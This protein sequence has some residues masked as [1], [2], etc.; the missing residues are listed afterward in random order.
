MLSRPI[1]KKVLL[2]D[3]DGVVLHHPNIQYYVSMR[4]SSY[5][6]EKLKPQV[7]TIEYQQAENINKILYTTFGHTLTGLNKIFYMEH[8]IQDFN[9]YVYDDNMMKFLSTFENELNINDRIKEIRF[10]LE[11]CEKKNVPVYIFSNAPNK[12]SEMIVEI[13]KLSIEKQNIIGSDHKMFE[14][15]M[16]Q[17]LKPYHPMYRR[18]QML[19]NEKHAEYP[20]MIFVDDAM[21]NIKPCFYM[22]QW[23]PILLSPQSPTMNMPQFS[24]RSSIHDILE[25]V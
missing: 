15:K 20:E 4:A 16:E 23:K 13:S 2:L 9:N 18:V 14:D 24:I 17:F 21:M 8:S 19:I 22:K 7:S 6:R 5:V 1:S 10:L 25:L 11:C 12:W 3:M